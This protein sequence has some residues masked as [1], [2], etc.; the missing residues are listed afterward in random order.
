VGTRYIYNNDLR[1]VETLDELIG[2]RGNGVCTRTQ[3]RTEDASGVVLLLGGGHCTYTYTMF[4]GSREFT[5]EASGIIVDSLGGT[6]SIVGGT[7]DAIGAFGEI[8][9]VRG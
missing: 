9:L 7:K 3:A 8:K 5:L 2:S 1:D 4:D 6:L